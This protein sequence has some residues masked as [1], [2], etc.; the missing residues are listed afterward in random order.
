[1]GECDKYASASAL[2]CPL[3]G[4]STCARILLATWGNRLWVAD[5]AARFELTIDP[6]PMLSCYQICTAIPAGR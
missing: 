2:I 6:A 1:M 3:G 4:G 5:T